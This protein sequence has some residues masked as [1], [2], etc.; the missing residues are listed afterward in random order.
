MPVARASKRFRSFEIIVRLILSARRRSMAGGVTEES[1]TSTSSETDESRAADTE[2]EERE[3]SRV[4]ESFDGITTE[5]FKF[6][7]P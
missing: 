3:S 6:G 7:S 2:S 1:T 5:T 4:G